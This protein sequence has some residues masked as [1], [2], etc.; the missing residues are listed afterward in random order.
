MSLVFV[1]WRYVPQ[2]RILLDECQ[3]ESNV[4]CQTGLI[5]F[6]VPLS[7]E[8]ATIRRDPQLYVLLEHHGLETFC[9]ISNTVLCYSATLVEYIILSAHDAISLGCFKVKVL[10]KL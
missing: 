5:T 7:T 4:A 8:T 6:S 10:R 1:G 2:E 3:Q 9:I